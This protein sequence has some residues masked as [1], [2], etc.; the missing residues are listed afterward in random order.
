MSR[1]CGVNSIDSTPQECHLPIDKG[2]GSLL[3]Y[4]GDSVNEFDSKIAGGS[5]E[6]LT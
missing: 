6:E 5:S 1:S 2:K 3:E 4:L